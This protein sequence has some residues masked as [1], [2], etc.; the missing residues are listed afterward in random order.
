MKKKKYRL[1]EETLEWRGHTLHRIECVTPF[2]NVKKG[3][4]GGW[5]EKHKNLSQAHD[6]WVDGEAKVYDNAEVYGD[7]IVCDRAEVCNNAVVDDYGVVRGNAYVCDNASVSGHAVV[8]GDAEVCDQAE[9]YGNA[10]VRGNAVVDGNAHIYSKDGV[11]SNAVI[12]DISDYSVFMANWGNVRHLTWT[13]PNDM[14]KAG[15]FYGTGEEL[16]KKGYQDSEKSG[17]EY[18]RIVKYVES[19]L[20]DEKK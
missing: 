14:W 11:H 10:V 7:A 3:D 1:T 18:E 6:C 12:K 4:K 5:V 17:R 13:K 16:I 19:M 20:E 8:R 2:G 9:I 15:C